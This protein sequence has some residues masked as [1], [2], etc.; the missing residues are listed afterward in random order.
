MRNRLALLTSVLLLSAVPALAQPYAYYPPV[1][2]PRYEVVPVA[3]PGRYIWQPGH[4][5][6]SGRG[7]V[8]VGGR[9]VP[10]YPHYAQYAPGG[11]VRRGGTW[12]WV[13]AH[14]R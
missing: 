2:P 11:W 13:P 6:W 1:P 5:Q 3:P 14:W 8:W 12:V 4:W 10:R 7:Y 9:Y